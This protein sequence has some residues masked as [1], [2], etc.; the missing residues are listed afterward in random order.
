[1]DSTWLISTHYNAIQIR[2]MIS[3]Y[4]DGSDKMFVSRVDEYSG[5]LS[6]DEWT[7]LSQNV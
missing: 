7:W 5:W 2:D 6:D 4:L 1:M 3:L